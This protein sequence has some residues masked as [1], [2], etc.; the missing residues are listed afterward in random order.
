MEQLLNVEHVIVADG[1]DTSQLS[2]RSMVAL[3]QVLCCVSPVELQHP[4]RVGIKM[5]HCAGANHEEQAGVLHT[6]TLALFFPSPPVLIFFEEDARVDNIVMKV[7]S[8]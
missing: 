7:D 3:G 8:L 4:P 5:L 6:Q 2:P 1:D